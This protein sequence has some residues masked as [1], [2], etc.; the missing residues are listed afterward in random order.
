[1][2]K[3]AWRLIFDFGRK[4]SDESESEEAKTPEAQIPEEIMTVRWRRMCGA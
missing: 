1:M 2:E 4:H 3:D